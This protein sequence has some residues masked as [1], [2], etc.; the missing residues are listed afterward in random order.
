MRILLVKPDLPKGANIIRQ[1]LPPL[2]LMYIASYLRANMPDVQ[3]RIMNMNLDQ[4]GLA[5]GLKYTVDYNPDIIG[6]GATSLEALPMLEF[7]DSVRGVLSSRA[8]I[9]AGGPH[10]TADAEHT[11]SRANIDIVVIGEGEETFFDIVKRVM[12][13]G[14][15]SGI[16]GTAIK[17]TGGDIKVTPP[18]PAQLNVDSMP[19]PAWDLVD[20]TKFF[21]FNIYSMNDFRFRREYTT[22]FSSR[23]CPYPCTY[24]HDIFGKGFRARS[25]GNVLDEISEL[26]SKYGI[27]EIHFLDDCFNLNMERTH[28]ILDGIISSGMDIKMAFPNGVR[29]DKMDREILRKFAKAG[30]YKMNFGVEAGSERIQKLIKKGLDLNKVEE[31]VKLAQEAGIFVHGFFMLGFPGETADEMRETINFAIDAGFDM[32]GFFLVKPF[33]GTEIYQVA[34]DMGLKINVDYNKSSYNELWVNLSAASDEELQSLQ[35]QAYRSFYFSPKRAVNI[36]RKLPHKRDIIR[37]FVPHF[38]VKFA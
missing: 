35:R 10:P 5:A 6:I 25:A 3:I 18:R 23:G 22:M 31:S 32:A 24:C 12:D 37:A 34:I 14:D 16:P 36:F 27:R 19:F 15:L 21:S 13:G 9:V 2:G 4:I 17:S 7:A 8:K 11:L 1:C 29:A 28:A 38:K 30:T 20:L 26:Y 33:P